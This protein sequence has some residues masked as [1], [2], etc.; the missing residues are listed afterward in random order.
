MGIKKDIYEYE[1]KYGELPIYFSDQVLYVLDKAKITDKD[2]PRLHNS[3]INLQKAKWRS[4][5]FTIYLVPKSTPRPRYSNKLQGFYVSGAKEYSDLFKEFIDNIDNKPNI[6]TTPTIFK[7]KT[8]HPIP[9]NMNK[10]EKVLAE[11]RLIYP[12]NKPDFDNLAKTYSDMTQKHLLMDD[13][14][15]IKS[16]IEKYYSCRPRIE[17][18]FQYMKDYD[19]QFNKKKIESWKS[20]KD[21]KCKQKDS[22]I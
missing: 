20:F 7:I 2:L 3:I 16:T 1:Q 19:C 11:L 13:S 22:I 17:V 21:L 4:F 6:I 18:E 15:I 5:K 10:I 8:F 12:I 9:N 14:I